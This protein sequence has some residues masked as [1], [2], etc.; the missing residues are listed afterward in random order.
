MGKLIFPSPTAFQRRWDSAAT[1][2]RARRQSGISKAWGRCFASGTRTVKVPGFGDPP[3]T[4]RRSSRL[5]PAGDRALCAPGTRLC[6]LESGSFAPQSLE[7]R[8]AKVCPPGVAEALCF[9][10]ARRSGS[11]LGRWPR[12]PTPCP[13]SSRSSSVAFSSSL[14]H[15]GPRFSPPP[16]WPLPPPGNF[17]NAPGQRPRFLRR[18]EPEAHSTPP[19]IQQVGQRPERSRAGTYPEIQYSNTHPPAP[20]PLN[21]SYNGTAR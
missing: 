2:G 14:P 15:T 17:L 19:R 10:A 6:K 18:P 12:A 8:L 5:G 11:Y 3:A 13:R 4:E 21:S 16:G 1:R 20:R 9:G 7:L